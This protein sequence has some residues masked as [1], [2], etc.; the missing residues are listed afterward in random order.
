[1][2]PNDII[3]HIHIFINHLTLWR[4]ATF[5]DFQEKKQKCLSEK[6]TGITLRVTSKFHQTCR[7]LTVDQGSSTG[8]LKNPS[9]PLNMQR[10]SVRVPHFLGEMIS[11][12]SMLMCHYEIF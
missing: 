8:V 1:M 10:G 9:V 11:C 3:L 2:V 12:F 5:G 6:K 7:L 4:L